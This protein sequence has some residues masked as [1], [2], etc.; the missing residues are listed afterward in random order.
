MFAAKCI[1]AFMASSALG[2]RMSL[3]TNRDVEFKPVFETRTINLPVLTFKPRPVQDPAVTQ[4]AT[5][6]AR[7]FKPPA[8]APTGYG[9]EASKCFQAI[10]GP[11][12]ARIVATLSDASKMSRQKTI[13][14][15]LGKIVMAWLKAE[16][17][18]CSSQ[19]MQMASQSEKMVFSSSLLQD[20]NPSPPRDPAP[21]E[22]AAD[23]AVTTALDA[24]NLN[25]AGAGMGEEDTTPTGGSHGV[26]LTVGLSGSVVGAGISGEVGI[27]VFGD[28]MGSVI[29]TTGIGMKGAGAGADL[30]IGLV[31]L[32]DALARTRCVVN[33]HIK[34]PGPVGIGSVNGEVCFS[35]MTPPRFAGIGIDVSVGPQVSLNPLPAGVGAKCYRSKVVHKKTKG[36]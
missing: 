31:G 30:K 33:V 22:L 21:E 36:R 23:I 16:G 14:N 5:E 28:D 8:I 26:L 24:V 27:V 6:A 2:T 25:P 4:I 11:L 35:H 7:K 10:L 20:P 19:I 18:A 32:K 12:Q 13:L 15:Q 17:K 3:I 9:D 1:I 34:I 29:L